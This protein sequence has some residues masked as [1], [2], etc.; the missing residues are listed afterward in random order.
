MDNSKSEYY[1]FLKNHIAEVE[2]VLKQ[3]EKL[4]IEFLTFMKKDLK[5]ILVANNIKK[6]FYNKKYYEIKVEEILKLYSQ[7]IQA[8]IDLLNKNVFDNNFGK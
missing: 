5:E 8:S 4:R 1:E 2:W 7:K 3:Q 6:T